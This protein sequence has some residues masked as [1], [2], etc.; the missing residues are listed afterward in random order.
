ME[1]TEV[2]VARLY[3][4]DKV[5][6]LYKG[7]TSDRVSWTSYGSKYWSDILHDQ[8]SFPALKVSDPNNVVIVREKRP[9][10]IA[11]CTVHLQ[12]DIAIKFESRIESFAYEVKRI[13]L[14]AQK[15]RERKTRTKTSKLGRT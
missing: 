5:H 1:K 8:M 10:Y 4:S 3:T 13:E 7:S 9:Q 14:K 2:G 6:G 15:R 12:K 11:R